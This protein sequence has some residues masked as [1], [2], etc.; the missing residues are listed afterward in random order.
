MFARN[1]SDELVGSIKDSVDS[2]VIC[3][4][5]LVH[6][7]AECKAVILS[8]SDTIELCGPKVVINDRDGNWLTFGG[9][10]IGNTEIN[11]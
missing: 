5:L 9:E 6:L 8:N 10:G 2:I 4:N 1:L 7:E 3:C 11:P